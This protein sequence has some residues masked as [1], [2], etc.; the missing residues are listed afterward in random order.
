MFD[1][2]NASST[3]QMIINVEMERVYK[4]KLSGPH[5]LCWKPHLNY[6]TAK[7]AKSI[8]LKK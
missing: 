5:K 8:A 6:V 3:I 4:N 7:M 2:C 1:K